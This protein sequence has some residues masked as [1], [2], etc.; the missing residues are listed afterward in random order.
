MNVTGGG[1]ADDKKPSDFDSKQLFDGIRVELEHTNDIEIAV[2]IAMDHLS[3]DMNY[4]K[5][6]RKIDPEDFE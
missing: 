4:Y 2:E 1:E 6:L 3:S 5:K